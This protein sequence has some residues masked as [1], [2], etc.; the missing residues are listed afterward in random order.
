MTDYDY[1]SAREQAKLGP[2]VTCCM[3]FKATIGVGIFTLPYAYDRCGLVLGTIAAALTFYMVT[4]GIDLLLGLCDLIESRENKRL[5]ED[6]QDDDCAKDRTYPIADK[7]KDDGNQEA[8]DT[9]AHR[10]SKDMMPGRMSANMFT[11]EYQL[12]PGKA[13]ELITYH[14]VPN[15]IPGRLRESATI[16]AIIASVGSCLGFALGNYVYLLKAN[17]EFFAISDRLSSLFIFALTLGLMILIIEPEKI[18]YIAVAISLVNLVASLVLLGKNMIT[19]AQGHIADQFVIAEPNEIGLVVGV[20]IFAFESIGL[21]VNVRRT[22][23]NKA[24]MRTYTRWTFLG[25][26]IF[27]MLLAVSFHLVFGTAKSFNVAFDYYK[28]TDHWI[29]ILKYFVSL[30]P[31]FMVPFSTITVI[32]IFEKVRP[33]SSMLRKNGLQSSPLSA[34]RIFFMRLGLLTLIFLATLLDAP[35]HIIFDIVGS[36]FGPFLG[37]LIPV[38]S[39]HLITKPGTVR[40]IHD[41]VYVILSIIMGVM[42][43]M[44]AFESHD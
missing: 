40:L 28:D 42:G 41:S 4:Y 21:I 17:A 6:K 2:F 38:L 27:F 19:I 35:I 29:F 13:Y 5:L 9:Q 23:R 43:V 20:S 10:T 1:E 30:N 12:L 34:W 37:M 14:Q 8:D 16:V 36:L 33:M 39:W 31:L 24:M 15:R 18:K 26:A 44:Y 11:V 25:A 32:E 22:T 7:L 3:I